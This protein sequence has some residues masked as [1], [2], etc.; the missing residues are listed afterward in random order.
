MLQLTDEEIESYSNQ[1]FCH[2]CK[3]KFHDVDDSEDDN[4]Y[5]SNSDRD[6]EEYDDR[7]FHVDAEELDDVNDDCYNHDD[8]SDVFDARKFHGDASEPDI[9]YDYGYNENFIGKRF[10]AVNKNWKGS[11]ITAI[12]QSN[13]EGLLT[14]S[15]I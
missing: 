14:V 3:K 10:H 8:D 5:D 11:V 13:R 12:T 15:V 9:N 7:K 1:R 6:G 2:I 4:D